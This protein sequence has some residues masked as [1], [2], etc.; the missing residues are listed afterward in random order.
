MVTVGSPISQ[1]LATLVSDPEDVVTFTLVSGPPWISLNSLGILSGTPATHDVGAQVLTVSINDGQNPSVQGTVTLTVIAPQNTAPPNLTINPNETL[2]FSGSTPSYTDLLNN[3]VIRL[4]DPAV[5]NVAGTFT[6]TGVIDTIHWTGTLPPNLI[7]TGTILDRSAIRVTS[8]EISS[9]HLTLRVP[10]YE[11]HFYQLQGTQNFTD[12]WAFI[13]D[14][15]AGTGSAASPPALQFAA[16]LD[17]PAKFF[18][19]VVTPAP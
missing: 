18:R 11:G 16:P 12:P 14:A 1:S 15:I 8:T 10:G 3:G 5:L 2:I 17:G 4:R 7:N 13:G 6:N 19:V 9:T